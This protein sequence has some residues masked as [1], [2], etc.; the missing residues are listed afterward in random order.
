MKPDI[1]LAW[2]LAAQSLF[3]LSPP[4]Q[5]L[6]WWAGWASGLTCRP[7]L[8]IIKERHN[9]EMEGTFS[10]ALSTRLSA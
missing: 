1:F 2:A 8:A 9:L 6:V 10:C 4:G 3:F 7:G 5:I